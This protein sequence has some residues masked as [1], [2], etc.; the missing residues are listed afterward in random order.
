MT[1]ARRVK[2]KQRGALALSVLVSAL[3][4]SVIVATPAMASTACVDNSRSSAAAIAKEGQFEE[5]LTVDSLNSQGAKIATI[6][7]RYSA[8][9]RCAWALIDGTPGDPVWVDRWKDGESTWNGPLGERDIQSGNKN[10]YTAAYNVAG[11]K[12]RACGNGYNVI[13]GKRSPAP[14]VCTAWYSEFVESPKPGQASPQPVSANA[15]LAQ[16]ILSMEKAGNIAINDAASFNVPSDRAS[17]SL[18]SLQL[19]DLAKGL[20]AQ[21]STRCTNDPNPKIRAA[22]RTAPLPYPNGIPANSADAQRVLQFLVNLG[23]K[24]HF[25]INTLFGQ[26]HIGPTSNHHYGR[27][28]DLGCDT[29]TG[30]PDAVGRT[31]GIDMRHNYET[32][33]KNGHW[34]YSTNG[35]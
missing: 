26:C 25:T 13:N 24:E 6:K 23:Q 7:L 5:P 31:P 10:T 8:K 9:Y 15:Q 35:A 29:G 27:A 3:G 4:V 33:A 1:P 12:I 28:V 32:C 18:P 14:I 2:W 17:R 22:Y 20:N 21:N 30:I 19:A 34:H 16:Q 11:Y